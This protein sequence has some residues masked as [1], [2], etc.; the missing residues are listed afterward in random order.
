MYIVG[1]ERLL[2]TA[3]LQILEGYRVK[4]GI[5]RKGKE[6][7]G[8]RESPWCY[9]HSYGN[10]PKIISQRKLMK[11]SEKRS[12]TNRKRETSALILKIKPTLTNQLT[13][14]KPQQ[15]KNTVIIWRAFLVLCI[16]LH[17]M[18]K[19]NMY[20]NSSVPG[21]ELSCNPTCSI[22]LDDLSLATCRP[23][24]QPWESWGL[25]EQSMWDSQ[26]QRHLHLRPTSAWPLN[27]ADKHL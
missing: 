12:E 19:K 27:R 8:E 6:Q 22:L 18:E 24:T 9:L 15:N 21:Q 13:N 2:R 14:Q 4:E 23:N 1:S 25:T 11:S 7:K 17:P 3:R 26:L 10:T 16:P 20:S 5:L